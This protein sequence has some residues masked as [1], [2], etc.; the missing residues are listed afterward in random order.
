MSRYSVAILGA[1]G[2]VGQRLQE[3]LYNHPFFEVVAIAGSP[4]HVGL[5]FEEI[6]W[7]LDSQRPNYDILICS[8]SD[9]PDV[10]ITFSALPS[11]VAEIVEPSLVARGIH[12]FS[13]ASAFRRVAGIPLVIPEINPEAMRAYEGHACATN[14]TVVPVVM[15][16]KGLLPLGIKSVTIQT[17]QALSGAGWRLLS[18][19]SA[20][21][22]DVNPF[23]QGEEEKLIAEFKHLLDLEIPVIASCNRVPHRDGHFVSCGVEVSRSTSIEEVSKMM[24]LPS[25]DLPSSPRVVNMIIE[26]SPNRAEHLWTGHGMTTTVGNIRVEGNIIRFDALSH[27]TIRGAAGGV[28]L[29]AEFAVQESYI[30]KQ[31]TTL[32]W[33][34]G[35]MGVTAMIPNMTF[36]QLKDEANSRWGEIWDGGAA[37]LEIMLL[38]PRNERKL[39]ELHG[40]MIDHGQPVMGIFHR[41]RAEANLLSEQGFDPRSSSFQFV[42]ISNADMGPWMQQLVTQ[43]GWLR[44]TIELAPVPFAVDIPN[45]R[46]FEKRTILCFRH[47]SLP[48]LEKYF[49]PYPIHALVGKA[50][51][52]LPRRQAAEL[53]RQ[54]AEILGVGL[55]KP[56][57]VIVE[58]PIVEPIAEMEQVPIA[59]EDA[60]VSE[61]MPDLTEEV[62][63]SP[64]AESGPEVV[65]EAIPLPPIVPEIQNI[66]A[67]EK[68]FRALI[69]ELLDAGV[70]PADMMTDPRLEEISERAL[71]Q[72]FE[73][74]PVFMQMVS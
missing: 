53:A 60:F 73:T 30:T 27:N 36:Q 14:C 62:S 44:G 26:E 74:W 64:S 2:L 19:E 6:E 17:R 52:S 10:D 59:V 32:R 71:A 15:P 21:A 49:L 25:L 37:R 24:T 31:S 56:E 29:L 11:N 48:P 16:I 20:L 43:E 38:C 1:S 72:S 69:Q 57:P 23:I 7:R 4:K 54:Q 51:V 65:T 66:P 63:S 9:I 35:C 5:M 50:F 55:A 67:I 39:L 45:Q 40:D 34:G 47:P 13:N 22:G 33:H 3:L 61:M 70:D 18:D 58:V 68:E 8:M 46:P 28:I 41:P 12:V 42:N